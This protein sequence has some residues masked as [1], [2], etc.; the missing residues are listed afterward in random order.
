MQR[1]LGLSDPASSHV[2]QVS[3]EWFWAFSDVGKP[4]FDRGLVNLFWTEQITSN[5]CNR[6]YDPVR[7]RPKKNRNLLIRKSIVL[8]A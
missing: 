6:V 4:S 1:W 2:L 5:L 8:Y 3:G 7:V